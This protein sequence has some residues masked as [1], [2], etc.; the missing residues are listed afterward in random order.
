[1]C[2]WAA[3]ELACSLEP[4]HV[5]PS[6][7]IGTERVIR[8]NAKEEAYNEI[9]KTVGE[10]MDADTDPKEWDIRGLARWA[11]T[12]FGSA[13][14]QNQLR[15]MSIEEVQKLLLQAGEQKI[16]S[17]DLTAI[18][19]FL[20]PLYSRMSLINWARQKFGIE[21]RPDDFVELPD[22]S[23]TSKLHEGVE[24]AYREREVR[25]PA[26]VALERTLLREGPDNAYAAD[27]LAKW[28]NFKF[29][30]GWTV[31][32][33]RNRTIKELADELVQIN[34]DYITGGKLEAEIDEAI[35]QHGG[36][37]SKDNAKLVE[38][39]KNRFGPAFDDATF[40]EAE[41]TRAALLTFGRDLLRRELTGLER[42]VLLEIYDQAW[43]DHMHAIDL[44]K[45]AIGLRGYAEQDP[46]IAYKREGFQ[47]FQEMMDSI[48]DKVTGII[49]KARLLD[50]SVLQS[51]YRIAAAQHADA[52]NTGFTPG[53]QVQKDR[54]AAMQA[55]GEQAIATIRRE[56]PKVGRN[57]PCPCGSGKKFKQCHGK[58]K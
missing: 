55:Q 33:I 18:E 39:A 10:Y 58:T 9:T 36:E 30:L 40:N 12:R 56:Q 16:E 41:D 27:A 53:G 37:A 3:T 17:T 46:K 11:E 34:R 19:K 28:V 23:I 48:Q 26:E 47:M 7:V 43:K 42:Y 35:R 52:T 2:D 22:S 29:N 5:I 51:R 1:V 54:D 57:E 8:N 24:A 25:Y 32:N 31:D 44:L 50:E 20:D 38:W 21:L 49:F 6:D 13:V 15:N 45:E 14:S 4:K